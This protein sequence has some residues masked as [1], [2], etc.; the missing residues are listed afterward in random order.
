MGSTEAVE[1]AVIPMIL[2]L[3]GLAADRR[4]GCEPL[5]TVVLLAVGMAGG[6]A[7]AYYAYRYQC[8]RAEEGQPWTRPG[9]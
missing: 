5:F 9:R 2:A 8:E 6:F 3:V 1:M 4:L 7:R